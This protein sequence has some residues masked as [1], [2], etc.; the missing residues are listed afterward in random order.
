MKFEKVVKEFFINDA[1][2][3]GFEN[4]EEAYENIVMPER[5]TEGSAG[6]DFA[7]PF[8]VTL[9]P[10]ERRTVPTGI[11]VKLDERMVLLVSPRSSTGCKRKVVFS[12]LLGWIDEDYYGNVDTD[13]DIMLPL[14]NTGHETVHFKAGERVAQGGI[15]E[16][17]TVENDNATGKRKGGVGSTGA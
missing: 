16:F 14:W 6:Y 1:E 13:G 10:D 9:E 3:N 15:F 2:M 12:N 4:A 8:D 5:Q 7:V 17:K 11:K